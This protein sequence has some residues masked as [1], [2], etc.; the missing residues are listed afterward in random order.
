MKVAGWRT[1]FLAVIGVIT[2]APRPAFRPII[3]ILRHPSLRPDG[4]SLVRLSAP[5]PP[6]S[7][8]ALT[9]TARFIIFD[10]II[11]IIIV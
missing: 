10:Y 5:P 9:L 4:N 3:E 6:K 2:V 11:T 1:E 7:F 8:N